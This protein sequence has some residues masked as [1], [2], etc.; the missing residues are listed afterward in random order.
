MKRTFKYYKQ[1]LNQ[2]NQPYFQSPDHWDKVLIIF[3]TTSCYFEALPQT[4]VINTRRSTFLIFDYNAYEHD[5]Y[6]EQNT[7]EEIHKYVISRGG[8]I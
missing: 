4:H 7:I 6:G 2:L 8:D 5:K 1:L 3:P